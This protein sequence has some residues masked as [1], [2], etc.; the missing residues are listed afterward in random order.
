MM[1]QSPT[2]TTQQDLQTIEAQLV[3]DLGQTPV[4]QPTQPVT[5]NQPVETGVPQPLSFSVSPNSINTNSTTTITITANQS[6]YFSN[7]TGVNIV[8]WEIGSQRGT[9]NQPYDSFVVSQDGSKIS[10]NVYLTNGVYQGLQVQENGQEIGGAS[11]LV[12][13]VVS[14]N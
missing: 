14:P 13:N 4:V 8:E 5:Q 12:N 1:V 10:F 6:G 3:Q 2:S 7:Y 11:F 9:P